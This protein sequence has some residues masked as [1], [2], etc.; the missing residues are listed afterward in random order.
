MF[1]PAGICPA[2]GN[3]PGRRLAVA[4][5]DGAGPAELLGAAVTVLAPAGCGAAALR[6]TTSLGAG[7]AEHALSNMIDTSASRLTG[8]P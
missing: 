3:G 2:G 7:P 6:G 4:S 1:E 8:T 5:H